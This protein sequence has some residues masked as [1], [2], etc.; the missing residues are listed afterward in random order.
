MQQKRSHNISDKLLERIISVAYGDSGW[1]EKIIINRK[2][3]SNPE[4]LQLLEEYKLTAD[5][6]HR[7]KQS[8]VPESV[9]DLVHAKTN[10]KNDA[11]MVYFLSI[12]VRSASK[13]RKYLSVRQS[14]ANSTAARIKLPLYC[15]SLFSRILH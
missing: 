9:M 5:S 7:I 10:L 3:K 2:A 1:L 6:V 15:S 4:I 8:E 13:R 14:R 12:I 11:P